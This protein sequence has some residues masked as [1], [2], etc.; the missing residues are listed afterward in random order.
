M[1][2][3]FSII[4][5]TSP[6]AG[7]LDMGESGGCGLSSCEVVPMKGRIYLEGFWIKE[8]VPFSVSAFFSLHALWF[9]KLQY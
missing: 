4:S 7:D 2:R 9:P 1:T 8:I 5:I 3:S 6:L